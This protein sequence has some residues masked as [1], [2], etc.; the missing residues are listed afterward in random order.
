M[1][2]RW[3]ALSLAV[4]VLGIG[5]CQ[6]QE[7][8]D[9]AIRR[10]FAKKVGVETLDF[11]DFTKAGFWDVDDVLRPI[12]EEASEALGKEFPYPGDN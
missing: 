1:I 7:D 6:S 11:S 9:A 3:I 8:R 12:Y 5:G 10:E 4:S 2:I